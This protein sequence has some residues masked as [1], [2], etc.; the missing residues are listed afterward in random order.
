MCVR[1]S[2][3]RARRQL[4]SGRVVDD[5]GRRVS[6]GN[7]AVDQ[8]HRSVVDHADES[9]THVDPLSV[10]VHEAQRP[11]QSQRNSSRTDPRHWRETRLHL[12]S[13]IKREAAA[14]N[15]E[16]LNSIFKNFRLQ[17]PIPSPN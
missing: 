6:D 12:W 7:V 13:R 17:A 5:Q 9:D 16:Q 1:M 4:V 14:E 10:E 2:I 3:I 8:R 15:G 11:D